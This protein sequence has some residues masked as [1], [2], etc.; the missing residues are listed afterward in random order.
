MSYTGFCVIMLLVVYITSPPRSRCRLRFCRHCCR[1]E[2]YN[3]PIAITSYE[4]IHILPEN[5]N[6]M[7]PSIEELE[8]EI[9][10]Q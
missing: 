1:L 5:F 4:G 6:D 2:G 8:A 7:L 10:K 9:E 3:Q